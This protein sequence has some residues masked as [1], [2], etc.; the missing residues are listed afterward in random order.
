MSSYQF[1]K[2]NVDPATFGNGCRN[3][4]RHTSMRQAKGAKRVLMASG[5]ATGKLNT[6]KCT[7]C[8]GWHNGRGNRTT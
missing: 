6:Y 2:T 5:Q 7:A 1:R 3:K 8:G 4:R